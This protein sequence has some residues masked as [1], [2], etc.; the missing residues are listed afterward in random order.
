MAA[1][2][3]FTSISSKHAMF[4]VQE[5]S[6]RSLMCIPHGPLAGFNQINQR[7]KRRQRGKKGCEQEIKRHPPTEEVLLISGSASSRGKECSITFSSHKPHVLKRH[8]LHPPRRKVSKRKGGWKTI[9]V[10]AKVKR[11]L[12]RLVPISNVIWLW[13]ARPK[14]PR[15]NDICSSFKWLEPNS[16]FTWEWPAR[17]KE[18]MNKRHLERSA[19]RAMPITIITCLNG[20]NRSTTQTANHSVFSNTDAVGNHGAS[21]HVN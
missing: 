17:P 10:G 9:P 7:R 15:T 8:S 4:T 1:I 21:P 18:S 19:N 20:S 6:V 3:K 2:Q 13:P 14:E 11:H 12:K 5:T 16:N